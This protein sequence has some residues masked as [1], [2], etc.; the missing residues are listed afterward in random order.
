MERDLKIRGRA[1]KCPDVHTMQPTWP[2]MWSRTGGKGWKRGT[3]IKAERTR[4]EEGKLEREE[5][6]KAAG[7]N[8]I[9]SRSPGPGSAA[10][11]PQPSPPARAC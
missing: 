1:K 9:C 6:G 7:G 10:F 8:I 2:Q 4:E 5:Q 11:S 3:G